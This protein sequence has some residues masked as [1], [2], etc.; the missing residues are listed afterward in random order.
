MQIHKKFAI[1]YLKIIQWGDRMVANIRSCGIAGIQG[2][3]VLCQCYLSGGMVRFDV[4]GLPDSSVKE[5]RD[6]V[7]AAIKNSGFQFPTRRITVN[8]APGELKKEGPIYDLPILISIL[9][10][11]EQLPIPPDDACFIGE[12]S[13]EGKLQP[14]TG[15][16][17]MAVAARDAGIHVLYIPEANA[18]EA[19]VVEGLTVYPVSNVTELYRH[20]KGE[21]TIQPLPSYVFETDRSGGADFSDV[22]GQTGVKRALEIAAAGSHHVLMIGPPGSG[23]SMLAKRLSSILPDM[24]LEESLESSKVYSVAGMLDSRQP[25]LLSRPFR[26]P[27][28]T[29]STV[30][31]SGG[32]SGHT[33]PGEIS[34]A[35]NGVLFLDELP[36]FKRETIEVLRQ[37]LEDGTVTVS[38][39]A[40]TFTYPS[41]FMLV[42]AMNPC[43]C[44]YY[45][46][47]SGRCNCTEQSVR[48]YRKRISGPMMD[49]IDLH[50]QV[51][52]VDYEQ[53]RDRKPAESSAEIRKRVNAAREIQL[54]RYR[55]T[56]I[57]C[58]A[59]LEPGMM[60]E[61]CVLTESGQTL[62]AGAFDALGLSARSHDRILKVARTIADLAGEEKIADIHVAEAI[63]Y[64]SL[65]REALL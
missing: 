50:I 54:E 5:S 16:L 31:M 56:G 47:P 30:G 41:R 22:M 60:R 12:L 39:I 37:P 48:T 8:L 53:L 24:T 43:K 9:C 34:L 59:Q 64:R 13:L 14:A 62:M 6:R 18:A 61:C 4:V 19:S 3:T 49:R 44:G 65:D 21:C 38:R 46:H 45:G 33:K 15:I 58:N 29:V 36:E 1:L 35:H 10:A 63:Q 40:G 42:G 27:H 2:Q 25:M 55:G 7:R 26:S 32:G 11:S 52:S 20:L 28:H 51:N 17:P 23:K 57:Y